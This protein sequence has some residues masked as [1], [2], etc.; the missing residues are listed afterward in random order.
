MA[1]FIRKREI[2]ENRELV[3]ELYGRDV[4]EAVMNADET[5]TF[6]DL[7]KRLGKI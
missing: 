7:L 4:Y 3:I 1:G 6:L 2:R 5:E